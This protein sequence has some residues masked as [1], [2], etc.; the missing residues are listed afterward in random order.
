MEL[1]F[2]RREC[3]KRTFYE[4][5][6]FCMSGLPADFCRHARTCHLEDREVERFYKEQTIDQ[7]PLVIP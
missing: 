4:Q 5:L 7:R 2:P 6:F 1:K 3:V